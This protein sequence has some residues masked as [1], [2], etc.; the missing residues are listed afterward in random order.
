MTVHGAILQD[1]IEYCRLSLC[2]C[3]ESI[4]CAKLMMR[5]F[6]HD[7]LEERSLFINSYVVRSLDLSV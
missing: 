7:F 6:K 3:D 2:I 5:W 4:I 1:Y